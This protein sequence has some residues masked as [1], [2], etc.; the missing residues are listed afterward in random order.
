MQNAPIKIAIVVAALVATQAAAV[1]ESLWGIWVQVDPEKD[2]PR[3]KLEI[4]KDGT[5]EFVVLTMQDSMITVATIS[6][7]FSEKENILSLNAK[8]MSIKVRGNEMDITVSPPVNTIIGGTFKLI[9]DKLFW[10]KTIFK[11]KKPTKE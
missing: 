8:K 4:R 7:T 10:D 5:G 1:D 6:G 9:D 3:T 2:V 11:R